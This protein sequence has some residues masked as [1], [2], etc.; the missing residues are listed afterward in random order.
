MDRNQARELIDALFNN[1]FDRDRYQHFLRNLLNRIEPGSR[2]GRQYTGNLIP[3]A[4]SGHVSQYWCLGKYV[5]PEGNELD[6]LVVEV[7]T[8]S[9]L[10][11]ARSALRNFAV[12]RLKQFEKEAS[13]IA[14]Y[15]QD[16]HGADWRFSYVKIEHGAYKDDKG[17]VKIRQEL[18]P[19][20]RHSFLVGVHENSHTACRQLLPLLEMDYADPKIEEIEAAFSI[21]KVTGEFFDQYKALFV[22][23]ADHLKKQPFF[24]Q[25]TDEE[26]DQA[27]T[28][29]AKKLLGQIVFLYF[30][31][32]KGWL[33]VAKDK[34][35]GDGERDFMRGRYDRVTAE[36]G[37]YFRDFLQYLFYE[38]LADDRKTQA[39]PGYYQRFDCRVPFLNG[40]LFEADYDWREVAIEIPNGLFHNREKNKAGDEGTGILDVFGRYNFTIKEDEPLD[41]E[42]AVDPEMLGKVFENM[43]EITE[44]KS[45]GAFYTPREIV[46]YMC[47]ES[48]I[49]YL[50]TEINR[51]QNE[52]EAEQ[53][54]LF[55][56]AGGDKKQILREDLET[57]VRRGHLFVE[58]DEAAL[59]ALHRIEQG[60]QKTTTKKIELPEAIKNNAALLDEKL[61]GI[62]VCD[63]AIG[64]GAFPV[65]LLHEIVTAR[66]ALAPHS[67][68]RQTPY[69]LKRHAIAHSIYGVDIDASAIDIARLR[70]W[71]SL[72]VDEDNYDDIAA[73][74]NL[75]YKIMQ[76][77]SL[78]EEY[79]GVKLFNEEFIEEDDRTEAKI[80]RL[81]ERLKSIDAEHRT[82]HDADQLTMERE[83][84]FKKE[85]IS[86]NK[87]IKTLRHSNVKDPQQE[88]FDNRSEAKRK[89]GQLEQ[90]HK[91]FFAASSPA[92][93]Q[94]IRQRIGTLEWELIETTLAERNQQDL[95]DK[96]QEIRQSG[97]K[98]FFLWKLNFSEVF[99]DKGGFDVVIGNPPYVQIQNFSGQQVQNDLEAQHYETFAKTGDIYCLFYEKGHRLLRDN[100]ALCFITSNKWMRAGY[101]K[102][103]R[104]FLLKQTAIRQ[105]IDFG[106]S[107]IFSEATTYTN[108]LLFEKAKRRKEALAWDLSSAF[109]KATSLNRMLEEN[110]AGAAL[111]TEDS[112]VIASP[113]MAT[114]KKRIEQV[115]TP[116]KEWDIAINYGIKTGFN[117][118]FIIDGRK[119]D[120]LIA[121]D[122]KSAE[123]IKPILRGRDIKRY[124]IDFAD[125]WLIATFPALNLNI[126]EYP[127]VRDYLASFGRKLHQTGEV[128]GKDAQGNKIKSRKKTGNKWFETQDQIAY[129][130]VFDKDKIVY[131]ET[132]SSNFFALDTQGHFMDKTTFMIYPGNKYLL[133][134]LNS[135][136]ACYF[137][138][139]IVSKMRGGFFSL[140]KIYVEQFPAPQIPPQKQTKY[141]QFVDYALQLTKKD[142]KLQSTYFEQLIDGLVYELYFPDEIKAAG[143]EILPHLGAPP[144]FTDE[145]TTEEKL[146]VI[147]AEFD[148]LYDPSHPVRNHL[149]TLDSVE[150]VKTI[151]EAL[152]R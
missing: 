7:K 54:S 15:A 6:L 151:R 39:D 43:L 135:E 58:N 138:N 44:R 116:L 99:K 134:V 20:R 82:L 111:F 9:K 74:P 41:K 76:G 75:D 152:K 47:Q 84:L 128:I 124:R 66:L 83:R 98:P 133:A 147:Q 4:F 23:L 1:P 31:Q 35:W 25:T 91:D 121:R 69:Q 140:S 12:N 68:N 32:K 60:E 108:V 119:K 61:A 131:P 56:A 73:L 55:V 77:N 87:T 34:H 5:D 78:V 11:R 14:F 113:K 95:L 46:H 13:L 28:R 150:V 90:L 110:P 127:A 48:L 79:W 125:L 94:E 29:F 64:S 142:V 27:V 143:K 65:G 145:M 3:D 18:T 62:K 22:K 148:R 51:A 53:K 21:E 103:M 109:R 102:K 16:D 101:G 132:S 52:S 100:G 63:P 72:I 19:A 17:K 67:G 149:E 114:I 126:D 107:P 92:K 2:G 85:R 146:A 139:S 70:L 106:D 45:K 112:F 26:T 80:E 105:L 136:V 88:L 30:L 42:V 122:P 96:L 24:R 123:V 37:N 120:E 49:K 81:K 33:G 144:P 97:E 8:F 57:L 38:A 93:K 10:E 117:E 137:F 89:A 36:G 130:P 86:I 50:H 129:Y 104:D 40:G 71:L 118:A 115:G 59:L 141:I